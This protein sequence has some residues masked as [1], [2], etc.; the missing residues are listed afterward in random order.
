MPRTARVIVPNLPH[1]I[2]HPGHNRKAVFLEEH[3]YFCYLQMLAQWKRALGVQ[4]HAWC[5]MTNHVH[6][7]LNPGDNP[8][9]IG[10]L[11]KRLAG[12]QT[13]YAN[14]QEGRTGSLWDGRYKSSPIQLDSYLLQCCRYVE[15]NPVKAAMV[16]KAEYYPWSSYRHKIGLQSSLLLDP[17]PC[18]LSLSRP[19]QQYREF[20][21]Q[22]IPEGEQHLIQQRVQQ[23]G[24]TG[25]SAFVDEVELRV[26]IRIEYRARGRPRCSVAKRRKVKNKSVPN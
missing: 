12:R 9:S 20:V 22:G 18:Y 15:L 23:N 10:L 2:V 24:L 16:A 6:L 5:L 8:E 1:H 14:K 19:A 21:E 11:M 17:D 7:V 26:G 13:R 3:D 25:N 4:V